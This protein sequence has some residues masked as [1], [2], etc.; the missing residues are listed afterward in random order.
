MDG[1][2]RYEARDMPVLAQL[3]S[4]QTCQ[5]SLHGIANTHTCCVKLYSTSTTVL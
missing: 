2:G 1:S 3:N 4:P 5:Q